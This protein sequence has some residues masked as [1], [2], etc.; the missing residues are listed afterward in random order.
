M[1]LLSTFHKHTEASPLP[2]TGKCE[3]EYQGKLRT[4]MC[5]L[6]RREW[7]EWALETDW[8]ETEL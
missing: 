4:K 6:C 1:S 7:E 2:I 5:D 3:C 8:Y